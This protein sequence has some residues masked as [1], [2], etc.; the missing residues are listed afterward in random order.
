VVSKTDDDSD[1]W[2]LLRRTKCP[3][4]KVKVLKGSVT[5][6]CVASRG[7]AYIRVRPKVALAAYTVSVPRR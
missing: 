5:A 3:K 7:R 4:S 6:I 1:Y 2:R